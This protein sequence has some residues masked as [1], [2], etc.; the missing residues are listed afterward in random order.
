MNQFKMPSSVRTRSK[1]KIPTVPKMETVGKR[2]R[3]RKG[4][5]Y[6][7]SPIHAY[8]PTNPI[9]TKDMIKTGRKM[10]KGKQVLNFLGTLG[11]TAVGLPLIAETIGRIP[12][13]IIKNAY[14]SSPS[15]KRLLATTDAIK[16]GDI[17]KSQIGLFAEAY[18][19]A[20]NAYNPDEE[21][22]GWHYTW[23]TALIASQYAGFYA[24]SEKDGKINFVISFR[25]TNNL[26]DAI[27][28]I[29]S[30]RKRLIRYYCGQKLEIP[31]WAASGPAHR[32]KAVEKQI[33][34]LIDFLQGEHIKS[35]DEIFTSS[36]L[37]KTK[38][39]KRDL[40]LAE[41]ADNGGLD[42]DPD[43][44][45]IPDD[46]DD[47]D[48]IAADDENGNEYALEEK[49]FD[50]L[51]SNIGTIL[52]TGHSLGGGCAEVFAAILVQLVPPELVSHIKLIT[53]EAMRGLD[54]ETVDKLLDDPTYRQVDV[55]GIRFHNEDDVVP[56]LPPKGMR[57]S[58]LGTPWQ[59][60]STFYNK[61]VYPNQRVTS[62]NSH[63]MD[64]VKGVMDALDKT[65]WRPDDIYVTEGRGKIMK[66]KK[67]SSK[68][69]KERMAYVR[70]FKRK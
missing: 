41:I 19:F 53:I 59:V 39:P 43:D 27:Q 58:H 49:E 26:N 48:E 9:T 36:Q 10:G 34:P 68:A 14:G 62:V 12:Y 4:A 18:N 64:S 22:S 52:I 16:T 7:P 60:D 5:I 29:R 35:L 8:I 1:Y 13:S 44:D 61:D 3:G 38:R 54:V 55:N 46:L 42:D 70:S 57:F 69:M 37:G 31:V 25:G 2:S 30:A 6:T 65:G 17:D 20:R 40:Q 51:M 21:Y 24:Y 15:E 56:H 32:V 45:F 63:F 67:K 50:D 28:D 23:L 47:E 33:K 11:H 66:K